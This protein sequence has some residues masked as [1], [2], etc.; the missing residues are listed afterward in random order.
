VDVAAILGELSHLIGES[1][2]LRKVELAGEPFGRV[3]EASEAKRAVVRVAP[4]PENSATEAALGNIRFRIVL[5]GV[6]AQPADVA[7]LVCRLDQSPYFR[8]VSPSFSRGAKLPS[9]AE[10][11]PGRK[12]TGKGPETLDVTE[13]EIS[14][15]LANYEEVDKP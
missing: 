5:A 14:C 1:V 12:P 6:A 15:Y 13:F 3:T 2:V 8:Q 7:D 10:M 9:A 11:T 4:R